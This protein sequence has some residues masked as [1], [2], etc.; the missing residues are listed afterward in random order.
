MVVELAA[1]LAKVE[2][3][4]A[5]VVEVAA[6][7]V[8][9]VV[10]AVAGEKPLRA[11]MQVFLVVE[12]A[13]VLKIFFVLPHIAA[14][15]VEDEGAVEKFDVGAA[16]AVA[17]VAVGDAVGDAAEDVEDAAANVVEG[18][19]GVEGDAVDSAGAQNVHIVV[20]DFDVDEAFLEADL[21]YV[22]EE[23]VDVVAD[24]VSFEDC[25]GVDLAHKQIGR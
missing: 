14:A 10:V 16:G 5:E 20:Q 17:G 2:A 19:E 24:Q 23:R 21:V 15:L 9:V 8:A 3:A 12:M 13:V 11:R 25:K 7:A 4:A 22:A 18:G 1:V 6:F